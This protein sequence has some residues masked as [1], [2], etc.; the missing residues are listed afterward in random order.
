MEG[1]F[2]T[3]T[4]RRMARVLWRYQSASPLGAAWFLAIIAVAFVACQSNDPVS[5][6][7]PPTAKEAKVPQQVQ[8]V[9]VRE[10]PLERTVT[11]LGSLAA[12]DQAT[13]SVKVP[14][15]LASIPVDFGSVVQRGQ[16]IAQV[17]PRDYQLRLQQAEAALAQARVRLGL[18]PQGTNDRVD[19]EQTSTVRQT[20]ALLEEAR[21]NRDRLAS[22]SDRGFVSR[23]EFDSAEATYKV[24][25]SRHQDAIEEIRNRQALLM[26]RRSELE[27]ARQQ[28]ADTAVFAPF[29][30]MIQTRHASIGEYL[31]AGMPVVSLVRMDPLRLRAEVPERAAPSVRA[32]QKIRVTIE[33][34]P[35]IHGGRVMRLGP[36]INE[37]NRM[38]TIEA[39]VR[40][41]GSLRPGSFAR[42]EIVTD[43]E[44]KAL[45]VPTSTIISFAGIEKVLLVHEGKTVEKVVM[46]GRRADEWVEVT[47]GVSLGDMVVLNP[48]NL[49][50]GQIVRVMP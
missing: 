1:I 50:A 36:T 19:P 22:L 2:L 49:Q 37:Q 11:V 27:I 23:S 18:S 9:A 35:T 38:L 13:L 16:L 45:T 14:G 20:R 40:N 28:L 44:D 30:G 34:D 10:M 4:V 12:H 31:A 46:T 17:E 48:G 3:G 39:D 21:Q 32:G 15:R 43:E 47:T 6:K 41:N 25:L 8:T 7:Q 26:Q 5:A 42:I 24:A 29:D 33:G